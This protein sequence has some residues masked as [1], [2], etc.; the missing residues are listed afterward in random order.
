MAQVSVEKARG[1]GGSLHVLHAPVLHRDGGAVHLTLTIGNYQHVRR[2]YGAEIAQ[3]ALNGVHRLLA[4]LSYGE[5]I[6]TTEAGGA[7]ELLVRDPGAFGGGLP[8]DAC[9]RWLDDVCRT[10]PLI[11]VETRA[12]PVHLWLGGSWAMAGDDGGGAASG[13]VDPRFSGDAPGDDAGWAARY[14]ADMALAT[15]I[16]SAIAVTQ[17]AAPPAPGVMLFWQGVRD[18][19]DASSI[20]Y[21]EALLRLIGAHGDAI[22]TTDTV[23]AL[24][25]LGF[26]R[27]VDHHVVSQVIDTL[28]SS[29]DVALGVNISARSARRDSLWDETAARL[30]QRPDVARR[31]IVEITETAAIP[32]VAAAVR[33]AR[34]LRRLGCRIALD[35]F[36]NGFASIRQLFAFAPDIAKI[37]GFFVQRAAGSMRQ[38]AALAHLAGLADSLGATVIIEGVES[39]EQAAI[40]SEAGGRWQQG[41]HWGRPSACRPWALADVRGGSDRA[42]PLP[43]IGHDAAG[44]RQEAAR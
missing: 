4:V 44:A 5:R 40:A 17:G 14:R 31:L 38:R 21:H 9:R 28:E 15:R 20:L 41:Y 33:F 13:S 27:L 23:L 16:L 10:M 37:G 35:D 26:A 2:A 30:A 29:P 36:G 12:G 3:D 18:A 11:P 8:A 25:R 22:S 7:I 39:A 24:E 43:P 34:D 19:R 1:E 42:A 6:A 32:D